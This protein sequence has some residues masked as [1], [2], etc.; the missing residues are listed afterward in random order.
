MTTTPPVIIDQQRCTGCGLCCTACPSDTLGLETGKAMVTGPACMACGH[1]AAICPAGA[2]MVQGAK[3]APLVFETFAAT[4]QWLA[5]GRSEINSLVQ[6]MR[7]RRSCRC[8]LDKPVP[9][10]LLRDLVRIG[11][12]APSGT[13]S[14]AWTF[15]ILPDRAG[16]VALGG[17]VAAYFKRLNQLAERPLLRQALKL[18]GR[19]ALDHYYRRHHTTTAKALTEW[20]EHGRDRLFHG[21][22]A[23]VLVGGSGP[24]SCPME[25]ALL[26]TQ[27]MLLAAHA[28]GLGSCLIGFAV[29]AM[30]REPAI[31]HF[32]GLPPEERIFSVVALGYPAVGYQ[33]ITG[34]RAMTPR[35]FTSTP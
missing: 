8:Y 4:D 15:T 34:R 30:K 28:M 18:I 31:L 3:N 19:P 27:N 20:E 32:L 21:A 13:N 9:A 23:A 14:Q 17:Q 26:A 33:K 22:T 29:E 5:P 16:V 12:T 1:C 11:T 35:L 7:S 6:L 25:D 2:I 24:A 10:E